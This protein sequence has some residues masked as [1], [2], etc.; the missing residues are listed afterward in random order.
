MLHTLVKI[1]E[2]W[3][4]LQRT[5]D[6][7]RDLFVFS[8]PVDPTAPADVRELHARAEVDAM[9]FT[10][11]AREFDLVIAFWEH[12]AS[13]ARR[14]ASSRTSLD[15]DLPRTSVPAAG[16]ATNVDPPEH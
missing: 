2:R 12:P 11:V 4:V 8:E 1:F 10:A 6:P 16:P 13:C 3:H 15:H 7:R 9:L 14:R 5:R